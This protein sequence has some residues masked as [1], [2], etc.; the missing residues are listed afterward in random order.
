M[1]T[2]FVSFIR[3]SIKRPNRVFMKSLGLDSFPS[4]LRKFSNGKSSGENGHKTVNWLNW[5]LL[6]LPPAIGLLYNYWDIV[7]N[8]LLRYEWIASRKIIAKKLV[9]KAKWPK[10]ERKELNSLLAPLIGTNDWQ[11]YILVGPRGCGKTTAIEQACDGKEGVVRIRVDKNN[12][13]VFELVAE[14]FGVKS[15]YYNFNTQDDLVN[16]FELASAKKGGNWVPTIIAE[17][18]RGA[19]PGTIENVAKSL[20]VL[21]FF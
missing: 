5:V 9:D 16:L 11:Y 12:V 13:N 8:Q 7:D 10:V 1:S 3:A 2:I 14:K 18:D 21:Y 19:E 15:P 17:I 20:K 4:S 6:G